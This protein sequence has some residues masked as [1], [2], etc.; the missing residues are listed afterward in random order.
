M[1]TIKD[2]A[3]REIEYAKDQSFEDGELVNR[4]LDNVQATYETMLGARHSG[5]SIQAALALLTRLVNIKPLTAIDL[6]NPDVWVFA[7]ESTDGTK[8]Y[9][10]KRMSSLFK[11]ETDGVIEY[12]DVDRVVCLD[13]ETGD[14]FYNGV[15]TAYMHDEYPI[16]GPTYYPTTETEF[17]VTVRDFEDDD[18]EC[19]EV[20]YADRPNHTRIPIN[21]F[22]KGGVVIFEP[23][24]DGEHIIQGS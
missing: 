10:C 8:T 16:T 12:E 1:S 9:Q 6:E 2:W 17:V 21:K 15:I 20:L 13:V 7:G 11:Q 19:R 23:K 14:R 3:G 5:H 22:F 24:S 18:D 4:L